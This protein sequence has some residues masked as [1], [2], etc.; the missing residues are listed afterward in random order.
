MDRKL[1]GARILLWLILLIAIGGV[2]YVGTIAYAIYSA[3]Y[4]GPKPT[5]AQLI[6]HFQAHKQEIETLLHKLQAEHVVMHPRENAAYSSDLTFDSADDY[7]RMFQQIDPA[8]FHEIEQPRG[9]YYDPESGYL[10]LSA[11]STGL[12]GSGAAKAFM[13]KP[14]NPTPL[15]DNLDAYRPPKG[16]SYSLAYRRIEGYWYLEYDAN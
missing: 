12:A 6:S 9:F 2:A 14:P 3:F 15:V 13:Y 10:Y 1:L 16:Q 7:R 5:D 11:W 4:G 8:M